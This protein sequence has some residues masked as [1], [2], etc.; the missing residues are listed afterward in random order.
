MKVIC[1]Y[2]DP[3]NLPEEIKTRFDYGLEIGKAYLV[4]GIALLRESDLIYY[5]VDEG[6]RPNLFPKSIFEIIDNTIPINWFIKLDENP[7]FNSYAIL[8]FYELCNEAN[9]YENLI[10]RE[11]NAMRIYYRRKIELENS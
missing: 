5:L 7:F 10:D 2:N 9:Y 1:K 8:G 6:G 4:M 3:E 11:E